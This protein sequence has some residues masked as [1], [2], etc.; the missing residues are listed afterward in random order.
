MKDSSVLSG[1]VLLQQES[2]IIV[3]PSSSQSFSIDLASAA[4]SLPGT[5]T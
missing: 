4:L 1:F 3:Q 2:S 5:P